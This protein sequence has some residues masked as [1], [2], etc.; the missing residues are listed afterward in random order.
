MKSHTCSFKQ[1]KERGLNC[2]KQV[3]VFLLI[4]C[5][6]V[7]A[8]FNLVTGEHTFDDVCKQCNETRC[9][10]D[11]E[12]VTQ[13]IKGTESVCLKFFVHDKQECIT[14]KST[15]DEENG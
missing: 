6:S 2:I 15:Q 1:G 10:E 5:S 8:S 12:N 4:I 7:K 11:S 9:E 14:N 13:V 3:L